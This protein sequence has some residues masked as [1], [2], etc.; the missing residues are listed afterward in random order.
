[1]QELK[2]LAVRAVCIDARKMAT[3]LSIQINKTDKNDARGIA[4][5]MRSG[6]YREVASKSQRTVEIGTLMASRRLLVEQKVQLS[7]AIRGHLKMYGIRL[8][9]FGDASF[10]KKVIESLPKEYEMAKKGIEGLLHS[11]EKIYE[12]IKVLTKEIE[13]LARE[14]ENV[15]RFMTIPQGN[16]I[17]ILNQNKPIS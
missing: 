5:A 7:N 15:K 11:F 1:M 8:G 6:L 9:T 13:N 14:D 16:R 17:K 2:K 4:D 12:E 10:S 3:L